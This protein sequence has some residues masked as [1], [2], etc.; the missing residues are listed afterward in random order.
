MSPTAG[1]SD[2]LLMTGANLPRED[3]TQHQRT[4]AEFSLD[5]RDGAEFAL[6]F[7]YTSTAMY[8][9]A[10]SGDIRI[11]RSLLRLSS[12]LNSR[13]PVEGPSVMVH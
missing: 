2:E 9:T 5:P 4:W 11:V 3:Q 10:Q 12:C 6:A 7:A 13:F 1:A 8:E